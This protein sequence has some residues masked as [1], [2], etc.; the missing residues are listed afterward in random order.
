MTVQTVV[1]TPSSVRGTYPLQV[2]LIV[3]EQYW[4]GSPSQLVNVVVQT[5]GDE[6]QTMYNPTYVGQSIPTYMRIGQLHNIS[7]TFK[8]N[9]TQT[10]P[11]GK[12][13]LG[14][15]SPDNNTIWGTN[16]LDLPYNVAPGQQV[17]I[18]ATVGTPHSTPGTYPLQV[19]LIVDE[20]YWIGNPSPLTYVTTGY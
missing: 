11:K 15:K 14:T 10:W 5:Q 19:Q 9:G 2:Q 20:Q 8:N 7:M 17:T 6:Y 13:R 3:D 4:I 1:G 18:Y 12:V 16:R